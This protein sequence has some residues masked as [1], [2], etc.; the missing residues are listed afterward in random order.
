MKLKIKFFFIFIAFS[1]IPLLIA[2]SIIGMSVKSKTYTQTSAMLQLQSNTAKTGISEVINLFKKIGLDISTRNDLNNYL[3]SLKL[4]TA[5]DIDKNKLITRFQNDLVRY[6]AFDDLILLDKNGITI[7]NGKNTLS[8]KDLSQL[9]YYI[10]MS[11]SKSLVVSKA[12]KSLS[13]G[14][15]IIVIAIP[16]LENDNMKGSLLICVSLSSL[17]KNYIEDVS[18]GKKGYMYIVETDGTTIAHSNNNEILNQTF[19]NL[20][21]APKVIQEKNGIDEYTYNGVSKLITYNT[22]ESLNWIYIASIPISELTETSTLILIIILVIV[23]ISLI[24]VSFLSLIISKKISNPIIEVSEA[25]NKV[26]QGDFTV[27]LQLKGKD[28]IAF[29]S[30]KI[31]DTVSNLNHLIKDVKDNSS[32]VNESS[33]ILKDSTLQMS[34]ATNNVAISIQDVAKGASDQTSELLNIVNT[35]DNFNRELSLVKENIENVTLK[36]NETQENAIIGKTKMDDLIKSID[37]IINSFN[38]VTVKIKDLSSSVSKIGSITDVINNL[39]EQTNLLSL[40]AAIEATKAGEYGRTFAVVADEVRK[41]AEASKESSKEILT[42]VKSISNETSLVISNTDSMEK[43]LSHQDDIAKHTV[44]AFNG[45]INSIEEIPPLITKTQNSI[46]N[47]S[48]SK[49]IIILKVQNISAVSE[50]M[51]ASAEQIAS[52][53]EEL[54]ASTSQLSDLTKNMNDSTKLLKTKVDMFKTT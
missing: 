27:S 29:M 26:S 19:L 14:N 46:D 31:N 36:T 4:N 25:M 21:V 54:T 6:Q 13:T 10:R 37:S 18:I 2:G 30:T 12:K 47:A 3:N 22:D 28:E 34:L 41:L 24:I 33:S 1:L 40:N 7:L 11:E 32:V 45:I 5:T 17:S 52:S 20:D 15:P 42:I 39:S 44:E 48:T 8:G 53:T 16:I 35:L 51:S 50:E 49:D 43:L 38:I 23:L 9:E